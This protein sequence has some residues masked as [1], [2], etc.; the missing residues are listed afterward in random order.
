MTEGKGREATQGNKDFLREVPS[1]VKA[2]VKWFND[3]GQ[4]QDETAEMKE[5]ARGFLV[6]LNADDALF[7]VAENAAWILGALLTHPQRN[8]DQ[9]I[10]WLNFGLALRRMA[11]H[12]KSESAE[13]K[14]RLLDRSLESLD[15]SLELEPTNPRAWRGRGLVFHMRAQYEEEAKCYRRA[16]DI[17][18]SDP[19]LWLLYMHALRTAG[20]ED[21]AGA[22]IEPAYHAYLLAGQPEELRD[23]FEGVGAPVRDSTTIH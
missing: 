8:P 4:A 6:A 7:P 19:H 12:A 9:P 17:D 15:R 1:E 10:A 16:L 20:K 2:I 11:L 18:S 23:V 21:E 22:T 5:F 3:G 13:M 14:E